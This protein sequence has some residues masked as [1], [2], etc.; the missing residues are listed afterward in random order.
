MKD[1][2]GNKW[3]VGTVIE[4]LSKEEILRRMKDMMA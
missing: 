3:T 2:A 4:D 1:V